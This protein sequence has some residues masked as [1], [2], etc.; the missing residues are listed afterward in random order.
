VLPSPVLVVTGGREVLCQN[1]EKLVRKFRK[2]AQNGFG[3]ELFVEPQ[4]SHDILFIGWMHGFQNEERRCALKAG[5]IA[6]GL[7]SLP[8]DQFSGVVRV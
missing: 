6:A 1:P 2:V 8:T 7:L 4:V 3:M 5:D